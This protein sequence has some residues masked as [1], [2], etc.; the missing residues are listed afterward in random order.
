MAIDFN[1]GYGMQ[2]MY[3]MN[4]A[5]NAPQTGSVMYSLKA[6]YGCED[7]FRKTPQAPAYTMP[8]L[9]VPIEVVKPSFWSRIRTSLFGC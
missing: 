3:G 6:K 9:P 5:N 4:G 1:S 8:V 2:Q 7:C